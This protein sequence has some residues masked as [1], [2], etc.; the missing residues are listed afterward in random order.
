VKTI[1]R[2]V[3]VLAVVWVTLGSMVAQAASYYFV[4]ADLHKVNCAKTSTPGYGPYFAY[5]DVAVKANYPAG[6][7]LHSITVVNGTVT[8]DVWSTLPTAF[9]GILGAERIDS[10]TPNY[11]GKKLIQLWVD[12]A[13]RSETEIYAVCKDSLTGTWGP[14]GSIVEAAIF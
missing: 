10:P 6:A 4:Y 11:L 1:A 5:F 12:G 7:V 3:I 8:A 9:S 14:Y 13:L 2:F